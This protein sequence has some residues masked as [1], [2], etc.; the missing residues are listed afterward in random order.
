MSGVI[1]R[2]SVLLAVNQET[3]VEMACSRFNA[4]MNTFRNLGF[5]RNN[6]ELRCT[7]HFSTLCSTSKK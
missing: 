4:F 5:V 1:V 6:G 3:M 2:A 7:V